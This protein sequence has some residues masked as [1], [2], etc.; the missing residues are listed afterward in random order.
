[1]KPINDGGPAFPIPTEYMTTEHQ[2]MSLRDWFAAQALI[3][4]GG[5]YAPTGEITG[6]SLLHAKT[7]ATHCYSMA[8]AMIAAREA[9][10]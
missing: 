2:G 5:N 8:D 6:N 9:K 7:V 4:M 10:Q 1:M 3:A